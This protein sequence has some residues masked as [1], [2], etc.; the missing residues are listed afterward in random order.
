MRLP[1]LPVNSIWSR[2]FSKRPL[3]QFIYLGPDAVEYGLVGNDKNGS[4]WHT[5]H[6]LPLSNEQTATSLAALLQTIEALTIVDKTSCVDMDVVVADQWVAQLSVPWSTELT[7]SASAQSFARSQLQQAGFDLKDQDTVLIDDAPWGAPRLVCAYPQELLLRLKELA[8]RAG[9]R[10]RSVISLSMAS[11]A[12]ARD[13]NN[14][15]HSAV[16]AIEKNQI[17]IGYSIGQNHAEQKHMSEI[18]LRH[19]VDTQSLPSALI[20]TWQRLQLRDPYVAHI[21]Q[22]SILALSAEMSL[23]GHSLEENLKRLGVDRV[24]YAQGGGSSVLATQSFGAL[25]AAPSASPATVLNWSVVL[26]LAILLVLSAAQSIRHAITS[27]SLQHE[28]DAYVQAEEPP[29]EIERVWT[30]DE[31]SH[32][33]SVNS[34]I[35]ALNLPVSALLAA[36]TPPADLRVSVVGIE[37]VGSA[38]SSHQVSSVSIIANART[39]ADMTNYVAYVSNRRPFIKA[40]LVQHEMKATEGELPFHFKVEAIW[41]D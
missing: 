9:L 8:Q 38:S 25:N 26:I 37:S 1:V 41:N 40:Y 5:H 7:Q 21:K 13:E 36:L 29:V 32:I 22:I 10:L 35:R 31:L 20:S 3:R 6:V 4:C 33:Q 23:I 24:T 18:V 15:S 19:V 30:K 27:Q 34:A 2:W 28:I 11:W 39:I 12:V 17:M 16:V 14:R